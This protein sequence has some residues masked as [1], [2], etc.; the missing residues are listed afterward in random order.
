MISTGTGYMDIKQ[1]GRIGCRKVH[2]IHLGWMSRYD[3]RSD[4]DGESGMQD[5]GLILLFTDSP[6]WPI[7]E[8]I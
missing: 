5:T 8:D 3:G 7:T 1:I 2:W 4:R 6:K